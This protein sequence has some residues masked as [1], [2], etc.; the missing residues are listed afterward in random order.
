MTL[1]HLPIIRLGKYYESLDKIELT[2]CRSGVPVASV[3]HANGGLIRR[4]MA[5]INASFST[6]SEIPFARLLEIYRAAGEIFLNGTLPLGGDGQTQTPRQYVEQLSST[7]GLP[8]TLCRGNMNKI[9]QVFTQMPTILGGLTRGMDLKVLDTGMGEHSGIPVSYY[10]AT[11]SLGAVLPS[12]S[13]GVHSLWLPAVALK[14]PVVLKPGREEPWT[15]FRIIQA[16]IAA[17]CPSEAFC[18]Y[19]TDHDGAET[20]LKSCGRALIFGDESTTSRYASN[21]A[22]QIHGPGRSKILIGEDEIERWA[23]HIDV[24]AAS[25]AENG[26]RSCINASSILVPAHGAEIA[27]ALAE[28]LGA[29]QPHAA[30]DDAAVLAGFANPRMAEFIDGAIEE[31]LKA[32]GAEEVTAKYRQGSRKVTHDGGIYLKPTIVYCKTWEHPL[33]NREFLF[34]YASVVE[35]PQARMLEQMGPSLVVTAITR[36]IQFQRQLLASPWIGR[37]NIGPL[38]TSRVRWDQPH[39]GNLFEFLY[40]RRAIQCASGWGPE[41]TR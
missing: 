40:Q 41:N 25:V 36:D 20:I 29:L 3:S 10:A 14:I 18:F 1:P 13:P 30:A 17:G 5:K 11:H 4:D 26:G 28:K 35:M 8:H 12:N 34:P 37:L 38:P 27:D 39:E 7:T 22:I 16:L 15:P 21:P 32:G 19:P 23:E 33:A 6:L 31:G 9:Y 24:L 2:D